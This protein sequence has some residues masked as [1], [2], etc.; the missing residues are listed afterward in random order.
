MNFS[1]ISINSQLITVHSI[2]ML[3]FCNNFILFLYIPTPLNDKNS[4]IKFF[5]GVF[6]TVYKKKKT[7]ANWKYATEFDSWVDRQSMLF[8]QKNVH[9][10]S[11]NNHLSWYLETSVVTSSNP[12]LHWNT[13]WLQSEFH[14]NLNIFQTK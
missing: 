1:W 11:R 13:N 14:L 6:F 12:Q 4:A 3:I 7:F 5:T 2:F 9:D 8:I 10:A